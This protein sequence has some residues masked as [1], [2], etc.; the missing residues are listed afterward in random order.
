M[1]KLA[2]LP[3]LT[4]ASFEELTQYGFGIYTKGYLLDLNGFEKFGGFSF[5]LFGGGFFLFALGLFGVL[6]LLFGGFGGG[7]L[8][9]DY[10][11]LFFGLATFFL[12]QSSSQMR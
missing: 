5:G 10:G 4:I 6:A 1:T 7:S 3:L 8:G 11:D 12:H 9:L 2:L